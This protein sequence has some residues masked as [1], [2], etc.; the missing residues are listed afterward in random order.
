MNCHKGM[1]GIFQA[2]LKLEDKVLGHGE[3][4]TRVVAVRAARA[5]HAARR[6]AYVNE[7]RVACGHAPYK[8]LSSL[9]LDLEEA[10]IQA[11]APYGEDPWPGD[12]VVQDLD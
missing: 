3:G 12:P 1:G 6:L 9:S 7:H 2:D 4:F 11:R 8:A 10:R 5:D